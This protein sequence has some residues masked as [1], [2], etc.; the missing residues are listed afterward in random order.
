MSFLESIVSVPTLNING[1]SAANVGKLSAN[2]IPTTASAAL[3]L[4]LVKGNTVEKQTARV[5]AHIRKMGFHVVTREPTDE[6]RSKYKNLIFVTQGHGYP[7]QR[8][9]MD[10]A[11]AIKIATA[12]QST[13]D[14][15]VVLMPSAGGSLPLYLFE[16]VTRTYPVTIPIVNYDNNQ[17]AENENLEIGRLS[18][19]MKTLAAIMLFKY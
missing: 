8:T 12:V 16:K 15:K 6:E 4:R 1:I 19:G 10:D 18:E 7:A 9:P 14:K 11:T 13:S 17:H 5:L 3:D 2:V